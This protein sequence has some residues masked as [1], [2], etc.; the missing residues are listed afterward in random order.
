[1]FISLLFETKKII[2]LIT[3]EHY[4]EKNKFA[5]V[6]TFRSIIY[7]EY[8]ARIILHFIINQT[9]YFIHLIWL[10]EFFWNPGMSVWL[11]F[12]KN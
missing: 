9:Y 2:E 5:N 11:Q 10:L 3:T 6:W 1:M 4:L 8:Y 12:W 7:N